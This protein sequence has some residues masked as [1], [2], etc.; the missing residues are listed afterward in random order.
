MAN[1]PLISVITVVRN[2]DKYIERCIKSV[3]E[4]TYDDFEYIVIDGAST[5]GTVEIIKKY[6]HSIAH[7]NSEPDGGIYDAMNK[8]IKV[9]KCEWIHL[10]NSDDYYVENTVLNRVA[11]VLRD[12]K[13]KFYYF[14][15][16]QKI[17]ERKNLYRWPYCKWKLW[18][19]AYLPHPTMFVSSEAYQKIGLYDTQF[20]IAADHDMVLRLIQNG[21]NPIYYDFPVSVMQLG[22]ASNQD[23]RVTFHDFHKVAV[24]NGLNSC[25]SYLFFLFKCLKFSLLLKYKYK[26]R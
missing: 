20:S 15:M 22:G 10:L 3:L 8:G 1:N 4:Q 26:C 11:N 12:P 14:S 18:Y 9:A 6:Q 2:N 13:K 25:L 24:R 16:I 23:Y 17:N 19:S 21:F 5:D 7:W